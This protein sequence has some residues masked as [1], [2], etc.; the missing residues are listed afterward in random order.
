MSRLL[1]GFSI[2]LFAFRLSA[3]D[4]GSADASYANGSGIS[5]IWLHDNKTA[6]L[7]NLGM[8]W[9]YIKY[10]HDA[11][12]Q[13]KFDMDVELFK[14]LPAIVNSP[15]TDSTNIILEHWVDG[16]GKPDTCEKC[17]PYV[18]NEKTKLEPDYGYLFDDNNLP[19]SLVKKLKYIKENHSTG[20]N[21]HYLRPAKNGSNIEFINEHAY[22]NG[23]LPDAGTRLLALY[24]YWNMIQY[25]YPDRHLIDEDWNKALGKLIPDFCNATDVV[26]YQLACLKMVV[27]INDGHAMPVAGID[28]L[29]E[30]IG[31]NI[32]PFSAQFAETRLVVNDY[33]KDTLGISNQIKRGDI[34]E[35]IDGDD[36]HDLVRQYLPLM[37]ASNFERKLSM[38]AS[39]NGPL[40]RSKDN[41]AKLTIIR[42]GNRQTITVPRIPVS[43]D[44]RQ[45]DKGVV[46]EKG[47]S[48]LSG[49]IGYMYP[50]MLKDEDFKEVKKALS[51]TKGIIIDFRCYPT[52]F[53]PFIYGKWLKKT[54]TPFVK[55]T[56]GD[57]N[58]PGL[59]EYTADVENGGG[60]KKAYEGKLVILVNS[61][62]QSSAE[63]QTMALQSTPGAIV[64]GNKTSGADGN[65]SM[66]TLPGGFKTHIS[67]I[68]VLYPDGT[69]TQR[70]GVKIDKVVHR[71]IAGIKTGKDEL[72]EAALSF[73]ND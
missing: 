60:G 19:S 62:T 21:H 29:K 17:T 8:V 39:S 47:Y 65:V 42:D 11:V 6:E 40:L 50:A 22:N 57:I 14:V 54:K 27:R 36:V 53:M 25:F 35:S 10:H 9:G 68:G 56:T 73:I 7:V 38:M 49:N 15:S 61:S 55:L 72:L 23:P 71:T 32:T 13:G 28:T 70:A 58:V 48:V 16:F 3:Q 37:P 45:V 5:N 51:E 4:T 44:M 24:R 46:P 33:Y 34:I 63:Y 52:T 30:L 41:E 1:I 69:E 31:S 59:F 66:I 18:K 2:L 43:P 20:K 12:R 67:G 64:I 26:K